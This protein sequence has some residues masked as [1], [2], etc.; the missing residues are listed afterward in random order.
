MSG[1]RLRSV[2]F[3]TVSVEFAAGVL[4]VHPKTLYRNLSDVPHERIGSSIRVHVSF[5]GWHYVPPPEVTRFD[6]DHDSQQ[7]EFVYDVPIRSFKRYRNGEVRKVGD[8]EVHLAHKRVWRNPR[9]E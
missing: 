9:V 8:Y 1:V 3:P 5:L 6:P 4:R 7:Y 2:D